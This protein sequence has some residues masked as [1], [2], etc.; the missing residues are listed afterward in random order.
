VTGFALALGG[1]LGG[2]IL[3]E[4]AFDYP[5]LG[6]LMGQAVTN[7]DYPLLQALMLLTTTGVLVANLAADML[8]GV[9]DPRARKAEG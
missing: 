3:V 5:G 4:S 6:R 7:K 1:M 8:Y 9:L 2:A